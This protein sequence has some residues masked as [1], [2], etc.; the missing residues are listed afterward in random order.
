[1]DANA[2]RALPHEADG[3]SSQSPK[4][5]PAECPGNPSEGPSD[6]SPQDDA[7]RARARIGVVEYVE[8]GKVRPRWTRK[9]ELREQAKA[10]FLRALEKGLSVTMAC[11]SLS[12]DRATPYLWKDRDE[13]FAAAW[14]EAERA[15][16]DNLEYIIWRAAFEDG[17]WRAAVELLKI[18]RPEKWSRGP[19]KAT[20]S[21]TA[22]APPAVSDPAEIAQRLRQIATK[23]GIPA[24][25][26]TAGSSSEEAT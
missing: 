24:V 14:V 20:A 2:A 11:R 10:T 26:E 21:D 3:E 19:R 17:Q 23:L 12:I 6:L 22:A 25:T 8:F 4:A 16:V 1:M 18:H 5:I 13:A 9:L 15:G 7:P